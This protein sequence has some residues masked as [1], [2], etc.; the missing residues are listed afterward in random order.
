M[1]IAVDTNIL[2]Y[3]HR[4]EAPFHDA[5]RELLERLMSDS[6]DWA[7]PWP[8]VHEFI[9]VVTNPRIF[10]IPTPLSIAFDAIGS[11]HQGGNLVQLS[12]GDGYLETLKQ[13]VIPTKLQGARIHDA[14]I[15]ALCV[16][17]GVRELWSA[18]RDFSLFPGVR[19]RNPLIGSQGPRG[20]S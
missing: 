1:N 16:Y 12:E 14:R 2:V 15:A 4:K 11:W 10:K 20:R 6:Q 18:E 9:A 8:C 5:A 7:V 3:A 17:H 19:V 13:T